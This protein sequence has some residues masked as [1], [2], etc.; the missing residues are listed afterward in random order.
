MPRRKPRRR[1]ESYS[2]LSR[3]HLLLL[4]RLSRLPHRSG[5]AV[6]FARRPHHRSADVSKSTLVPRIEVLVTDTVIKQLQQDGTFKIGSDG[7]GDATLMGDVVA[8]STHAGTV[9]AWQCSADDRIQHDHAIEVSPRR[10]QRLRFGFLGQRHRPDQFL[11]QQ[12][13]HHG[14]ARPS[15]SRPRILPPA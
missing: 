8:N 13:S 1:R 14:Q 6:L 9:R 2:D 11:C 3:D 5:Q 15:H 4:E 12:R 7:N 10:A